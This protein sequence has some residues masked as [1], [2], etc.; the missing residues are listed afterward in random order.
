MILSFYMYVF[1]RCT[2]FLKLYDIKN[3]VLTF[4]YIYKKLYGIFK[5]YILKVLIIYI[6]I[7]IYGLF[8]FNY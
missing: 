1:F 5:C 7:Y 8:I 3:V 4:T 6:Y 2:T